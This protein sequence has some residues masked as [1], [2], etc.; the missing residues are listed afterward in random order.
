MRLDVLTRRRGRQIFGGRDY[1]DSPFLPACD[2]L[3]FLST[4]RQIY[5]EARVIF[6]TEN[7]FVF[8]IGNQRAIFWRWLDYGCKHLVTKIGIR[9]VEHKDGLY[10]RYNLDGLVFSW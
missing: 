1:R 4:C 9:L 3:A 10:Y 8:D 6:W 2:V 5:K 7:A